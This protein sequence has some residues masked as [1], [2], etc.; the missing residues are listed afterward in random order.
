M[1]K[2]QQYNENA[3]SKYSNNILR[4]ILAT[5]IICCLLAQGRAQ[6]DMLDING[7][8]YVQQGAS[9]YVWGDLHMDGVGELHNDGLI[10]VEGDLLRTDDARYYDSGLGTLVMDEQNVT[11]NFGQAIIGDF[12]GDNAI[13]NLILGT[14]GSNALIRIKTGNVE[15]TNTLQITDIVLRTDNESHGGDGSLYNHEIYISNPAPNALQLLGN[16]TT[17]YIEGKLRREVAAG[18]TY[19]FDISNGMVEREPF[20]LSF[21]T[22][23]PNF[24][25]LTYF[26]N[27]QDNSLNLS[28]SCNGSN[29]QADVSTGRWVTTP[30]QPT[31]YTYDVTLMPGSDLMTQHGIYAYN[32]VAEGGK[33]TSN[34]INGGSVNFSGNNVI[35]A[36]NLDSLSY[37]DIIGL[38]PNL[39]IELERIWPEVEG[40]NINVYWTTASET[41]NMGFELE[42]STDAINFERIAWVDGQGNS[43]VSTDYKHTDTDVNEDI[44][45]YYRIKAIETSGKEEYSPVV[46]ASLGGDAV[47]VQV[48]PNP[49]SQRNES[50]SLVAISDGNSQ[51]EI[52]GESG[53]L[54]F[55]RQFSA[56]KG[57]I[58]SFDIPPLAAGMHIVTMTNG[59]YIKR[60]KLMVAP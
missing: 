60:T 48:F 35:T 4:L 21:H 19:S 39:S 59:E 1:E 29:Y 43:A 18:N 26:Q 8:M 25:I 58:I 55:S 31:G 34:C 24:N 2:N 53:Q 41:N 45:Y 33:L 47:G 20:E 22:T 57:Q 44:V 30:S 40:N 51:I 27:R 32:A 23:P 9:I 14:P 5:I 37:F 15:V 10:H 7:Q 12:T 50:L 6:S 38:S 3:M 46:S 28:A 17:T 13:S 42:R 49:I 16:S 56:S 52:F 54:M 11:G 36:Q